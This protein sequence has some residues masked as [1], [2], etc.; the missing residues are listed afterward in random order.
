MIVTGF[1]SGPGVP[2]PGLTT[3]G[4]PFCRAIFYPGM[5]LFAVSCRECLSPY[6]I[7]MFF[8]NWKVAAR[9]GPGKIHARNLGGPALSKR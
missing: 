9:L 1:L 2:L 6:D 7:I 4:A 5:V 3:D 8:R